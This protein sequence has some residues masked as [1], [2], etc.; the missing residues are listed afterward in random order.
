MC[1]GIQYSHYIIKEICMS[2]DS[3]PTSP[4]QDHQRGTQQGHPEGVPVGAPKSTELAE[5]AKKLEVPENAGGI[6]PGLEVPY[7]PIEVGKPKKSRKGL[8]AGITAIAVVAAGGFGASKVFGSDSPEDPRPSAKPTASGPVT[9]GPSETPSP[10]VSST[11]ETTPSATPSATPEVLE[12]D[13]FYLD[14]L[15]YKDFVNQPYKIQLAWGTEK[16]KEVAETTYFTGLNGAKVDLTDNIA[17]SQPD[18]NGWTA[19]IG[20]PKD[21]ELLVDYLPPFQLK[22]TSSGN[23][24]W[25]AHLANYAVFIGVGATNK[26]EDAMKLAPTIALPGSEPYKGLINTARTMESVGNVVDID[27]LQNT[28][29]VAEGDNVF[30]PKSGTYKRTLTVENDSILNNGQR[31]VNTIVFE[32]YDG[33]WVMT[34]IEI[35]GALK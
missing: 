28:E 13:K 6:G 2:L 17:Q 32:Y 33:V 29:V 24:I 27:D 3:K 30:D 26:G 16:L 31:N 11:P 9:P 4:N 22:P 20:D 15:K 5:V 35:V 8:Y 1:F 18:S 25:R 14:T 10:S 7:N 12:I 23:D 34:S 19:H 21:N